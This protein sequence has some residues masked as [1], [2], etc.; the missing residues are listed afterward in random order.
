MAAK[1]FHES[2]EHTFRG[3]ECRELNGTFHSQHAKQAVQAIL[4]EQKQGM[5][6]PEQIARMYTALSR[7]AKQNS[8]LTARRDAEY[9]ILS[10]QQEPNVDIY[11]GRTPMRRTKSLEIDPIP[12]QM[13]KEKDECPR[14]R[15]TRTRSSDR[16]NFGFI[17]FGF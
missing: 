17:R 15:A 14:R 2:S 10:Q 12:L 3:L 13:T 4:H 7:V 6:S 9:V 1:S 8:A 5:R 11:P 16:A